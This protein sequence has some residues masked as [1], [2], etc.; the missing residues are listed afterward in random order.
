MIEKAKT[1]PISVGKSLTGFAEDEA[2]SA[3]VERIVLL[4]EDFRVF[5]ADLV[6]EPEMPSDKLLAAVA[7][8]NK[9]SRRLKTNC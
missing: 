4:E 8:Y 5:M 6:A 7:D 2:T 1:T 9:R 3:E